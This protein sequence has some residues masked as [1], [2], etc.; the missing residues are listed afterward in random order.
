MT[1]MR[2]DGRRLPV[3]TVLDFPIQFAIAFSPIMDST[4]T[5]LME[6][7]IFPPKKAWQI[8]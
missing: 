5:K 6:T 4:A 2:R 3:K 7:N 1:R 8:I